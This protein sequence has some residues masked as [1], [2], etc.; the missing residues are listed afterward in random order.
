ML[1]RTRTEQ[2]SLR[3]SPDTKRVLQQGASIAGQ[4]LTDFMVACS[5]ERAREMLERQRVI[6]MSQTAFDAFVAALD[7]PEIRPATPLAARAI[8]E[9]AAAIKED[10]TVGW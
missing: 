8:E 4:T 2:V 3:L 6:T 9:Y 1:T 5:A 7:E 10:G